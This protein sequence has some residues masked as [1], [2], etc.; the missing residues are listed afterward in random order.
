MFHEE[1]DDEPLDAQGNKVLADDDDD[2]DD[3]QVKGMLDVDACMDD[4]AFK[5]EEGATCAGLSYKPKK[6]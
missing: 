3:G 6:H 5:D 4:P 2:D 1:V